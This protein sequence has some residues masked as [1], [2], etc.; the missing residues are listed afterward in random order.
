MSIN[1]INDN[2]KNLNEIF[3]GL[4]GKRVIESE[5]D[6]LK[7]TNNLIIDNIQFNKFIFY[8]LIC[9]K[10]KVPSIFEINKQKDFGLNIVFLSDKFSL[11]LKRELIEV[12]QKNEYELSIND[13]KNAM[14]SQ[15]IKIY[16]KKIIFQPNNCFDI[17]FNFIICDAF[18]YLNYIDDEV[19]FLKRKE[20]ELNRY[21]VKSDFHNDKLPC[22]FLSEYYS[23]K[24][25]QNI[26]YEKKRCKV[27]CLY[28]YYCCFEKFTI[29]RAIRKLIFEIELFPESSKESIKDLIEVFISFLVVF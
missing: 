22:V 17:S 9:F 1:E 15:Y 26:F 18:V 29:T 16:I 25:Y 23:L 2:M 12:K 7:I 24:T 6:F 13:L 8:L 5:I 19:D 4:I 27:E 11:P 21:K 14:F 20:F 3:L 10:N 28:N